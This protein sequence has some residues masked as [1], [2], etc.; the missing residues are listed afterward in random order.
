MIEIEN[1]SKKYGNLTVYDNFSLS[2]AEGEITCILGESGSGKTTLLNMIARLIEF[3]GNISPLKVSYVFQTPCLVPNL[4][5]T[6]NLKLVC[7][8]KEKIAEMLERVNLSEK[9][10]V[11]PV[12][13]SGG[14]AKRVALC[15]AFLYESDVLLLDEPFSSLDIKLK[16][17]AI[18]YFLNLHKADGRTAVFVTHSVEEAAEIADRII[19]IKNGK[20][21]LD[22]KNN[23]ENLAQIRNMLKEELEK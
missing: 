21:T 15:R 14:Q 13:L 12:K 2:L 19:V 22:V 9:A 18:N 20:T 5:V 10:G 23:K 6:E 3:E 7:K 16:K 1:V 8:S 4:T 11:Y 17:Q